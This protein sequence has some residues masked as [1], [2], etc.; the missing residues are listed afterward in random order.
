[1]FSKEEVYRL[2]TDRFAA[3][4]GA[5]PNRLHSRRYIGQLIPGGQEAAIEVVGDMIT[6]YLN[7]CPSSE[8]EIIDVIEGYRD[9]LLAAARKL[10]RTN[11]DRVVLT[12]TW[13]DIDFD[14]EPYLHILLVHIV[15]DT[16]VVV[17]KKYDLDLFDWDASGDG[18]KFYVEIDDEVLALCRISGR[19]PKEKFG[20]IT[21]PVP[22]K[23]TP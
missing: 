6:G 8:P 5:A 15:F 21:R 11:T 7:G 10:R 22:R 14:S 4:F 2:C 20:S 16:G 3:T 1:M 19:L 12:G 9:G 23:A 13:V 18:P 17:T